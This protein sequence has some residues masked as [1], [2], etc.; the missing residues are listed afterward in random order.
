MKHFHATFNEEIS[1]ENNLRLENGLVCI[2]TEAWT[3]AEI[4][5]LTRRP[6]GTNVVFDRLFSEWFQE[7]IEAKTAEADELLTNFEQEDI[8]S[9][10]IK[11]TKSTGVIPFVGAGMSVSSG[12]PGWT[13]FL[14][15]Q[16]R[17]TSISIETLDELLIK[18]QFEEAAQIHFDAHKPGF[19]VAVEGVFSVD[20]AIIGPVGFLPYVFPGCVVTTNFDSVLE[21]SYSEADKDFKET[22]HNSP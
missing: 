22:L 20:K 15:K 3:A 14:R 1:D 10:L 9:L 13:S 16:L 17:R 5:D 19:N 6:D 2:R 18:G 4:V 7:R 21:R 12:Y 8:F 11:A